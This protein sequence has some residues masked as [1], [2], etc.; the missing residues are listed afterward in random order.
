MERLRR[1]PIV[2][3][4]V[5]ACFVLALG[6]ALATPLVAP[7]RLELVCAGSGGIKL[8][9]LA[10]DGQHDRAESHTLD[11][12]LCVQGTAPPPAVRAATEPPP[13][14]AFALQPIPAAE[15]AWRVAAPLPARGPPASA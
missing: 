9:V 5:L 8:I 12:P 10:D 1:H 7:Q 15:I 3:R 4:F 11:C 14:L 6:T 13:P 2:A